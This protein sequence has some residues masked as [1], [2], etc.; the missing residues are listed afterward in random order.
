M[1]KNWNESIVEIIGVM[2]T[3]ENGEIKFEQNKFGKFTG[4]L[5]I[6]PETPWSILA[7]KCTFVFLDG[8]RKAD[9]DMFK[10]LENNGEVNGTTRL[11]VTGHLVRTQGKPGMSDFFNMKTMSIRPAANDEHIT[12]NLDE[13]LTND[14]WQVIR[15]EK[16]GARAYASEAPTAPTA[17][18]APF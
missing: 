16:F 18:V 13:A 3:A 12:F 2:K 8:L 17:P 14:E 11:V 15:K 1:N 9:V 6:A 7:R 10:V 4:T 5:K